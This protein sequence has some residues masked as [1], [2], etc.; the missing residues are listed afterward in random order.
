[1]SEEAGR[2][3]EQGMEALSLGECERLLSAGGVGI[4]ALAGVAEPVLRPVNFAFDQG[5]V[6]IR[7][8]GEGQILEAAHSSEPAS[9]VIM[10]VDRLE[11]TGWSVVVTGALMELANTTAIADVPL[12]PWAR[13]EKHH[14][15]GLAIGQISGRRIAEGF[16][17]A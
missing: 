17:G 10:D 15:V 6:L 2:D 14:F 13:A 1:M 9:F 11:H 16:G 3:V 12:R 7:R 5:Q 4:L 8:T